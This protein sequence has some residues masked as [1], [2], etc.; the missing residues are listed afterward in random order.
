[1]VVDNNKYTRLLNRTE[2]ARWLGV[3]VG[4]LAKDGP[5][6]VR[7]NKKC[8][9]Y[10][11]EDVTAWMEARKEHAA[12]ATEGSEAGDSSPIHTEK[13]MLQLVSAI[14]ELVGEMDES[15]AASTEPESPNLLHN[16]ASFCRSFTGTEGHKENV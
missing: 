5:P 16:A 6:F 9:C 8:L 7:I 14:E 13:N 4:T 1:M 15:R 11:P 2:V 10:K 3:S 12:R